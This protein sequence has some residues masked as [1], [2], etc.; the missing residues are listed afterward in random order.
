MKKEIL[1]LI[2]TRNIKLVIFDLNG[3]LFKGMSH[4]LN[5]DMAKLSFQLAK[6]NILL[7]Y[8][9][10]GNAQKLF[11]A[12]KSKSLPKFLPGI[13]SLSLG[14]SKPNPQFYTALE[15]ILLKHVNS[16]SKILFIDDKKGNLL[17]PEKLGFHTYHYQH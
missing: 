10:N 2:K 5:P 8:A 6:N 3:V 7:S 13:D 12:I 1:N 9:T 4:N 15:N 11:N 17:I 14:Y 16:T